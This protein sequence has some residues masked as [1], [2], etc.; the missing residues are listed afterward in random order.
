VRK[1]R[2]QTIAIPGNGKTEVAIGE[3]ESVNIQ[4][5]DGGFKSGPMAGKAG[6]ILKIHR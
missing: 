6:S 1:I 3:T 2:Y 5:A 4:Q